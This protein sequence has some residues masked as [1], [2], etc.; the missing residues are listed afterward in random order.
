MRTAAV[1]V[2]GIMVAVSASPVAATEPGSSTG[3]QMSDPGILPLTAEQQAARPYK[4]AALADVMKRTAAMQA[5]S[6]TQTM[7]L[8]S[9]DDPPSSAGLATYAR[10]QHRWFYCGP[11]TVQ[12]V[13]NEA[14]GY[15]Y[16]STN[17]QA[18]ASNKYTQ[19]YISSH[20]TNT[21]ATLQTYLS[22]LIAG[23]N[24]ATA[25]KRPANFVYMQDHD[26]SWDEFHNEAIT[27]VWLYSMALAASVNPKKAGSA[28]YLDSWRS[29]PGGDYGH[30]IPLRGYVGF[31]QSTALIRYDDSSGGTD[32]VTG[33]II[34]G[35]TG[36]FDDLSYWVYKTIMNHNG[37]L[38]W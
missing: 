24:G 31:D 37:N 21:D 23:M 38:I 27:D 7:S 1:A 32:D 33:E 18:T 20:W 9:G 2:L 4:L 36:A 6:A 25:T 28:Y 35:S 12:V 14:W 26:P 15:Y 13:A 34:L 16:T 22:D 3:A 17:G 8:T 11:A 30:Y 29:V 10:H 19:T 5:G